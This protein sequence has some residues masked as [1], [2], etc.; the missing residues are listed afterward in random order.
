[1]AM[2]DLLSYYMKRYD[3]LLD[4]FIDLRILLRLREN[5]DPAETLKKIKER[6]DQTT[7]EIKD[8]KENS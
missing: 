7:K 2:K 8:D 4:S 1:M 6:L 3:I 5:S